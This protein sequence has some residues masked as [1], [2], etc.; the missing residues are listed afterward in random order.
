MHRAID[1]IQ[2]DVAT[3]QRRGQAT[4]VGLGLHIDVDAGPEGQRRSSARIFGHA[5][6][7]QFSDRHVV[8]DHH[9][10]E[11][12]LVA[13]QIVED[14]TVRGMGIPPTSLNDGI[15]AATPAFT[16]AKNGGR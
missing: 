3:L 13:Q 9:A 5:M 15:T 12:P 8:A 2:A 7:D 14:A 16:A 6:N 11:A 4:H 10:I 1:V